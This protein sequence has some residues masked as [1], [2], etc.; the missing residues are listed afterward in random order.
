MH[1]NSHFD[2]IIIILLETDGRIYH[3]SDSGIGSDES[4]RKRGIVNIITILNLLQ[5]L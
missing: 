2:I 3:S 1:Y 4:S 5:I